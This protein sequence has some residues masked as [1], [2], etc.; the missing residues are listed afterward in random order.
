M[1]LCCCASPSIL[2][3][4]E[5]FGVVGG[6]GVGCGAARWII[7]AMPAPWGNTPP[8]YAAWKHNSHSLAYD[9]RNSE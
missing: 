3:P 8:G 4:H 2:P 7:G 5:V 9:T 1:P 6:V